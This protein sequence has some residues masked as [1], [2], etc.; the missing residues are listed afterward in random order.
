MTYSTFDR[1]KIAGL[2]YNANTFD[3]LIY[4]HCKKS[5]SSCRSFRALGTDSVRQRISIVFV[6]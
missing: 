3:A 4:F 1:R 6:M 2:D 5:Q